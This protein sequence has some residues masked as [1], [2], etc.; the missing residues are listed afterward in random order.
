[1]LTRGTDGEAYNGANEDTYC[2]VKDMAELVASRCA[3]SP[4]AVKVEPEETAREKFGYAPALRMNLDTSKLRG[5]GWK[6]ETGLED[7]YRRMIRSMM[8]E[9]E[10]S[11][12]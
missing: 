6:P 11:V 12:R 4:I 7:M 3:R 9:R 1:M 8:E 5:L 10:R 2:S